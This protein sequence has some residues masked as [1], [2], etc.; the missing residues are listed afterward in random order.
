MTDLFTQKR[1]KKIKTQ[2]SFFFCQTLHAFIQ[3]VFEL[4]YSGCIFGWYLVSLKAIRGFKRDHW[5]LKLST[6][7]K[8]FSSH[9]LPSLVPSPSAQHPLLLG[10]HVTVSGSSEPY[11]RLRILAFCRICQYSQPFPLRSCIHSQGWAFPGLIK[12]KRVFQFRVIERVQH[13]NMLGQHY[14]P[15]SLLGVIDDGPSTLTQQTS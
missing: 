10:G 9:P 13:I 8:Q 11:A 12:A 14:Q 2:F 3:L 4:C 6:V 7:S 1:I 15:V 5:H